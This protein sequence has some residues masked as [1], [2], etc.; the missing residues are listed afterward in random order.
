MRRMLT[1]L[2]VAALLTTLRMQRVEAQ[3]AGGGRNGRRRTRD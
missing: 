1:L 3:A 2:T